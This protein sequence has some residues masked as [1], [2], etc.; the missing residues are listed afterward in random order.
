MAAPDPKN[1]LP[2]TIKTLPLDQQLCQIRFSSDGKTLFA[3]SFEATVRRWEVSG[4]TLTELPVLKGHNGW[5]QSIGVHPAKNLL[6]SADSW[7]QLRGWECTGKECKTLWSD[8]KAHDGW[9]HQLAVS[10][11]G[12]VLATVGRDKTVRLTDSQTGQEISRLPDHREDV[13][14]V[15]FHPDGKHFLSGDLKGIVK[16]WSL[17]T[18]KVIREFDAKAM[19]LRDRIQDVGGV[20]CFAFDSKGETLFVGGSVP[21]TGGF[22]QGVNLL[23]SFNWADGKLKQTLKGTADTEGYI[24]ELVWHLEGYLL[25]VS[26]GQPGNGK[27][28]LQKPGEEKPFAVMP[29]QNCHSL[30]LHPDRKRVIVSSTNANSSGN[31]RQLGKAKEYPGNSSP[32]YM[33]ELLTLSSGK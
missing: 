28:F 20:R 30:T 32:L 14:A 6:Y 8:E 9:I 4:D 24:Y 25:G 3:G 22:V 7:G 31:G 5:V 33:I 1:A 17:E 13:L 12:K 23:L 11:D 21:K 29:L 15:A 27:F 26:S 16:Q 2:K 19:F 18:K 10:I